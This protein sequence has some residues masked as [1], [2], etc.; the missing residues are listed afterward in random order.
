M[1]VGMVLF[2]AGLALRFPVS[3]WLGA[4]SSACRVLGLRAVTLR[5]QATR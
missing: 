2:A 1:Q 3:L 5:R 4:A